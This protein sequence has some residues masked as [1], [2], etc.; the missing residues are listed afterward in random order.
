MR[1]ALVSMKMS[2]LRL[3]LWL[4][5]SL[6]LRPARLLPPAAAYQPPTQRRQLDP[7][8]FLLYTT[9]PLCPAQPQCT[10]RTAVAAVLPKH[11]GGFGY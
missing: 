1:L 4:R 3:S 5:L 8:Y 11:G 10:I 9:Q 7:A 2:P 6:Q